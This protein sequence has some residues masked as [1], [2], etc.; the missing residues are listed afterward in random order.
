MRLLL[1]EFSY[2]YALT[3]ELTG[4]ALGGLVAAPIFPSL[5]QEGQAGG[6]YDVALPFA[7]AALYV[8][9]KL[10]DCM[11][12]RSAAEW[13]QFGRS[14]YR[15]HLRPGR[16]SEQHRMLCDL[17]AAGEEVFYAAPYF[18]TTEELNMFYAFWNRC[19]K[20][21]MVRTISHWIPG[22]RRSLCRLRSRSSTWIGMLGRAKTNKG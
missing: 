20:Q 1:S 10:S 2:G 9:F 11:V 21:C 22:R 8:Q 6:G 3:Q 13:G 18:H 17:Q 4:G 15:M 19:R 14:Y 12:Y 5:Y 7:G 16:H